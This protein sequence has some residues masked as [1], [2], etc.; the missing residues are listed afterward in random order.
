[1]NKCKKKSVQWPV[2]S[3]VYCLLY[4]IDCLLST[5]YCKICYVL[6]ILPLYCLLHRDDKSDSTIEGGIM[7][8]TF[9]KKRPRQKNNKSTNFN[10]RSRQCVDHTFYTAPGTP[11]APETHTMWWSFRPSSQG[12]RG[13]QTHPQTH[14][15]VEQARKKSSYLGRRRKLP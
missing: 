10:R 6:C 8:M 15:L 9:I 7:T 3:I 11:T 14:P 4:S 1:M 2:L 12:S 5:W 13:L